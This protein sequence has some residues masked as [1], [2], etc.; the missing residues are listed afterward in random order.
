MN[1]R[2]QALLLDAQGRFFAEVDVPN[3][4]SGDKAAPCFIVN[5]ETSVGDGVMVF[6]KQ[7]QV[8]DSTSYKLSEVR[9]L[10]AY[11]KPSQRDEPPEPNPANQR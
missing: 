3:Q 8:L 9:F 5:F 6:E 1:G 11:N 7:G 4:T 10:M 2:M